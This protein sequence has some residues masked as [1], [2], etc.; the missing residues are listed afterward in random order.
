MVSLHNGLSFPRRRA[1]TSPQ[2]Q[3]PAAPLPIALPLHSV[4]LHRPQCVDDDIA[5]TRRT[6]RSTLPAWVARTH[7]AEL[8]L[9]RPRRIS[10][11]SSATAAST[12]ST[13]EYI[14]LRA[15]VVIRVGPT[16]DLWD[17]GS[18]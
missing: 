7:P 6:P 1:V 17:V 2:A 8:P 9:P 12:Q 3:D 4:V 16:S 13:A 18:G 10:Y 5:R 15:R 14:R 11:P